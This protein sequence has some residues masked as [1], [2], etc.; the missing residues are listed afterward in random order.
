MN[1]YPKNSDI[2]YTTPCNNSLEVER[3]IMNLFKIIFKQRTDIGTE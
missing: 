2:V 1:S 3:D